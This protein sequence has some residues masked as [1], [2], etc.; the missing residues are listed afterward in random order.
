MVFL[1]DY[2]MLGCA[3]IGGTY[4]AMATPTSTADSYLEIRFTGGTLASGDTTGPIQ[5]R[6]SDKNIA[7]MFNQTNDY[8]F[9]AGDSAF[10][11]SP[12][13]T[14]YDAGTLVWGVEPH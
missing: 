8:S 9:N 13:I 3:T 2:A 5:A 4:V 12:T 6:L 7:F 10:T 1:C 11:P 14:V